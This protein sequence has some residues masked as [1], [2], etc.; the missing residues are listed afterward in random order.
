MSDGHYMGICVNKFSELAA[1]V[2]NG[3][4]R[5]VS[6]F[7]S[8]QKG[9]TI[10]SK[11]MVIV[12]KHLEESKMKLTAFTRISTDVSITEFCDSYDDLYAKLSK[13]VDDVLLCFI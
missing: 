1:S 12:L 2:R 4:R 9:F 5:R 6:V 3:S 8:V 10:V 7:G 13:L 11:E